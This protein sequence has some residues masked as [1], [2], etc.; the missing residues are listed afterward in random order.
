[1]MDRAG[2][3]DFL[4]HRRQS[5][6]PEDV[7]M[8]RGPRRRTAGLRR[9]EV[10]VLCHMSPDYWS[11]LEQERGP[12]PSA[13]MVG[14]IA[15][16]LHLTVA[17]RDHLFRLAGHPHPPA[18]SAGMHI[19]PGVLRILDRLSDTPAEV[20][21]ELGETLRQTPVG[22]ALLG[23]LTRFTGPERSIGYRWFALPGAR[24]VY[25]EE[26][27]ASYSRL[28]A[29]G[30]RG[31]VGLRGPGSR[32]ADLAT[33]LLASSEEF[34]EV[35]ERQEVGLQP[36]ETKR[37]R[38]P[39]VGDIELNCQVMLAPAQAQTLLVYTAAPGSES[40]AKLELLSVLGAEGAEGVRAT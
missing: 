34:R 16:G 8:P 26:D 5:L 1:M 9:E 17:E 22:V 40:H 3:A 10:A 38:L 2:L 36:P 18:A 20:V 14:S 35:W 13:Q 4:R 24:D 28:Y 33:L 6:Q 21:T 31:V 37:Y 30:L 32:A 15:Q 29:S 27:H 25:P 12:R 11:R 7:G 39:S 19:S 23:D